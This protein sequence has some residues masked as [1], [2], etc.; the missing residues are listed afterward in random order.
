MKRVLKL[1]EE[2]DPLN[3]KGT[4]HSQNTSIRDYNCLSYATRTF[5]WSMPYEDFEERAE[6]VRDILRT[7]D[8]DECADI[9]LELDTEVLLEMY[10]DKIRKVNKGDKLN[11]DEVLMAFREYVGDDYFEEDEFDTD[12]HAIV[13]LDGEWYEKCGENPPRQVNLDEPW[14]NPSGFYYNSRTAFFAVKEN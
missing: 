12:F 6:D 5:G 3:K 8:Y 1:S 13:R 7:C 14:V 2:A 11:D 10:G 9:L 4:R